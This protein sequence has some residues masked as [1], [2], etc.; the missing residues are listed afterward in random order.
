M[1]VSLALLAPRSL[2]AQPLAPEAE[3]ELNAR[4]RS[5]FAAGQKTEEKG[6]PGGIGWSITCGK[7]DESDMIGWLEVKMK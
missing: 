1:C 5:R 6:G 4:R 2:T 3:S 7:L